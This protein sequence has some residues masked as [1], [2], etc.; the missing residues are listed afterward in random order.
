MVTLKINMVTSQ[1]YF[2]DSDS[3]MYK[4]K[5]K[6]SLNTAYM[7]KQPFCQR[8]CSNFQSIQDSFFPKHIKFEK[9]KAFKKR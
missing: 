2:R 6:M 9:R 3:L 8:N 5:V 1:D 4:L 7:S